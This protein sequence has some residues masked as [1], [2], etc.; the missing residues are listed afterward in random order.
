MPFL[1]F[2]FLFLAFIGERQYD[3]S[4]CLLL[5]SP[6]T[7]VYDYLP[8]EKGP[9]VGK[10]FHACSAIIIYMYVSFNRA[11]PSSKYH[12]ISTDVP[13]YVSVELRIVKI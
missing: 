5:V 1:F 13:P 11:V 8:E 10:N 6:Y 3:T 7:Y 9:A 4:Y 2:F 12:I